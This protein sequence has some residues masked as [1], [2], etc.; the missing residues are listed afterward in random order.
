VGSGA[1]RDIAHGAEV[2]AFFK[3]AFFKLP[4]GCWEHLMLAGFTE[5]RDTDSSQS[6]SRFSF[7]FCEHF[8]SASQLQAGKF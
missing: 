6:R 5:E 4:G 8:A 7:V 3:D 2:S 1:R